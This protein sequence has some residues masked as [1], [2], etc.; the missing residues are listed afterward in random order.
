MGAIGISLL[1]DRLHFFQQTIL[2]YFFMIEEVS[3]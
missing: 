3:E 1:V 2:F